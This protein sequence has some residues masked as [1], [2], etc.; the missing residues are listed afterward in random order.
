MAMKVVQRMDRH[1][2]SVEHYA[3]SGGIVRWTRNSAGSLTVGGNV[4]ITGGEMQGNDRLPT[5]S[6]D[7][8]RRL[9]SKWRRYP[10]GNR[11]SNNKY[12]H[13]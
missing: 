2:V 9:S 7:R 4:L 10:H 8:Y 5:A 13:L 12:S 1:I 11:I 6:D 3:H